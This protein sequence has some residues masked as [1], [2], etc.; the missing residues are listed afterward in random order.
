M[1]TFKLSSIFDMIAFGQ[2][3][4]SIHLLLYLI[5]DTAEVTL[6][7]ITT[8]HNLTLHILTV[9]GVR[10][11]HGTDFSNI[12]QRDFLAACINHQI[13]DILHCGTAFI[14]SLY[15]QVKC[16]AV[17]IHL[18]DSFATQHD[19]D[20]LLKLRQRDAILCHQLALR[21]NG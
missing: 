17:V 3:D 19:I 6:G 12:A 8:D 18:A 15:R 9:D 21:R 1:F 16:L 7:D 14:R 5:N 13:T 4:G 11:C 20:I 10:A 2:L